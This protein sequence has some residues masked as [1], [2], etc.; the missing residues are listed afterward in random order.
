M[1]TGLSDNHYLIF[2]M[3]KTKLPLQECLMNIWRKTYHQ[4]LILTSRTTW[5]LRITLLMFLKK[6]APKKTKN[7]RGNY[8]PHIFKTLRLTIVKGS[9][10]KNKANK[11]NELAI[12][13]LLKTT[14]LN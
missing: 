12:N 1:E 9:R 11:T 4:S 10:L 2:S 14:K 8:R 5:L 3:M 13:K 6:H 7:F